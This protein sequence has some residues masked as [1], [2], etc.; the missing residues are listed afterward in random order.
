MRC[1]LCFLVARGDMLGADQPINLHLLDIPVAE[2]KL[3][4]RDSTDAMHFVT[5]QQRCRRHL[6]TSHHHASDSLIPPFPQAVVMELE[7]LASPCLR[8]IVA[9]TD[10]AE[11]FAGVDIALL[12]GARPRG[13]G[14]ERKDLLTANASIFKG[15]VRRRPLER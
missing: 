14:M 7:D 11:A 8:K 4:V 6:M 1:S 13:P 12:V 10:Y 15:Q 9:T 5:Q 3:K 2:A